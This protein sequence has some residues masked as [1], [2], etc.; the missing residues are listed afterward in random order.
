MWGRSPASLLWETSPNSICS[1][2]VFLPHPRSTNYRY[3]VHA[4]HFR[5]GKVTPKETKIEAGAVHSGKAVFNLN[6]SESVK[7]LHWA[8]LIRLLQ[9]TIFLLRAFAY[10]FMCSHMPY[11][12]HQNMWK[13]KIVCVHMFNMCSMH[14]PITI[15]PTL[16]P[17]Y[18]FTNSM[19][20]AHIWLGET[21]FPNKFSAMQKHLAGYSLGW[22]R[23]FSIWA[24]TSKSEHNAYGHTET[25][26]YSPFKL[27][28]AVEDA[29]CMRFHY[30]GREKVPGGLWEATLLLSCPSHLL[31]YKICVCGLCLRIVPWL[32][33]SSFN[34]MNWWWF[35]LFGGL[36]RRSSGIK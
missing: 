20:G 33:L 32:A 6:T 9:I 8:H 29:G 17:K 3:K 23:V 7:C 15:E 24:C 34:L 18:F 22:W 26:V 2:W 19:L 13:K 31:N 14:N 16:G 11:D 21:D 10:L 36:R 28:I 30:G 1:D 5:T 25:L 35:H 12:T 27:N 4:R